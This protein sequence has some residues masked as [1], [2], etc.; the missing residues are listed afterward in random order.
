LVAGARVLLLLIGLSAVAAATVLLGFAPFGIR[1]SWVVCAIVATV[2]TIPLTTSWVLSSSYVWRQLKKLDKA[3]WQFAA[4]RTTIGLA[5]L[6]I[7]ALTFMG[8]AEIARAT[9]AVYL[10]ALA[11]MFSTLANNRAAMPIGYNRRYVAVSMLT[12]ALVCTALACIE[13]KGAVDDPTGLQLWAERIALA[14]LF[15]SPFA[16]PL[17]AW[18]GRRYEP[19]R[20]EV[21]VA[22]RVGRELIAKERVLELSELLDRRW[23]AELH[24]SQP[25]QVS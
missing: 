2:V 6:P 13:L 22:P 5:A 15:L 20:D 25:E 11:V 17:L 10:L 21:H 23:N 8:N 1:T 16:G 7:I 24:S 12:A 14:A 3:R 4:L 19:A 9:V 18:R